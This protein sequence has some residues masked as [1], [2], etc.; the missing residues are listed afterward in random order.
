[1]E[2]LSTKLYLTRLS[3]VSDPRAA[4]SVLCQHS[5]AISSVPGLTLARY[6]FRWCGVHLTS[7][8]RALHF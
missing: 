4:D 7:S 8:A 1:L 5:Q 2:Y 3:R 6:R